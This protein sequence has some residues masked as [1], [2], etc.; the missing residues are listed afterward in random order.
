VHTDS[1]LKDA[2]VIVSAG[3]GIGKRENLSLLKRLASFFPR[4]AIGASR[5]V[6]DLG[7]LEHKHQIGTTGQNVSPRLYIACGISGAFQHVS[8]IR[9]AQTII[10]IN[11]DPHAGIFQ[12]AHYCINEDLNT[13]IPVL[14]E[15]LSNPPRLPDNV[16]P[17]L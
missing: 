9:G 15:E 10:A 4:S 5:S 12:V 7:W 16:I 3:R 11:T 6:C 13:F 14:L 1:T 2:E 17:R 8:G